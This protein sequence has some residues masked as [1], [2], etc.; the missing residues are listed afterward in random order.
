MTANVGKV[1]V[2]GAGGRLGGH[3][4]VELAARGHGT[5]ALL[6]DSTRFGRGGAGELF[7]ADARD[8]SALKGAC[9]GVEGV[10]S[11]M[12][13]SLALHRLRGG[14]NYREVDLRANLNLLAEARASGV[15]RFVYVSL[16]GAERLRG[17]GYV[18]AHEEFVEALAGSGLDYAVV[19]PTGF[20]Y[21][22]GE[23]FR[24]AAR[25]RAFVIGDGRA[26]TNPIHEAEV[27]RACAEALGE[28]PRELSVG[29]PE[30]YTR[31]EIAELVFEALGRPPKIVNI[32]PW[33]VRAMVAP[34]RLFNRRL[35]DLFQFGVAASTTDLVAPSY[36]TRSLAAYFRE[37]AAGGRD[38]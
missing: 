4:L 21:V 12:G 29:G 11:A 7:V 31:Q 9:E 32:A 22:F 23:I 16:Y 27:A 15:R 13:A 37:L 20:F 19:R 24:M 5:R 35:W 1:L 38:V 30:T 34:S 2:A 6:R 3:L 26:R 25:G 36:G 33:L 18:D 14:S 8:A 17:L 28:S 10:I